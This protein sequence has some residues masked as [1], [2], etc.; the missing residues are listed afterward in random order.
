MVLFLTVEITSDLR[1]IRLAYRER[2]K[3]A[4]PSEFNRAETVV[5]DPFGRAGFDGSEHI[6]N[7]QTSGNSS[8]N[9]NVIIDTTNRI[10]M[11]VFAVDNTSDVG[12]EVLSHAGSGSLIQ[13]KMM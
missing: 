13:N 9:V 3:S 6:R 7:G 8:E 4:L 12:V 1:H 11:P 5:I 2:G 10:Q